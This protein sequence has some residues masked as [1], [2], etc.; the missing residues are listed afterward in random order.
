MGGLLLSKSSPIAR[1]IKNWLEA[2]GYFCYLLLA[3][4]Y[5]FQE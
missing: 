5:L 2:D 4:G 1:E 3:A